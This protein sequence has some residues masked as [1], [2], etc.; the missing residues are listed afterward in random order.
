M[1]KFKGFGSYRFE[2][3]ENTLIK[4]QKDSVK[5]KGRKSNEIL[6]SPSHAVIVAG[7]NYFHHFPWCNHT[8]AF[9]SQNRTAGS[10]FALTFSRA[11]AL[12]LRKGE[13]TSALW[14]QISRSI[15]GGAQKDSQM[16]FVMYI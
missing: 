4:V 11:S 16:S 13:R 15:N 14:S 1:I 3:N 9:I 12:F 10:E 6:M 2:K 7:I 8:L 5:V